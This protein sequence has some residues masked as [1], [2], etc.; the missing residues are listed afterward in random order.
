MYDQLYYMAIQKKFTLDKDLFEGFVDARDC[1]IA[2]NA[3][4]VLF[5]RLEMTHFILSC[6]VLNMMEQSAD[7]VLKEDGLKR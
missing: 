4:K 2:T 3:A 5:G 1:L 6:D 7:V